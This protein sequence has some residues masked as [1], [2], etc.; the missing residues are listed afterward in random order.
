MFWASF[1]VVLVTGGLVPSQAGIFSVESISRDFERPFLLSTSFISAENQATKLTLRYAQSTYGIVSLNET[2][3]PYMARNY[4]L[5]P[6][7]PIDTS[8][9]D[10]SQGT[11]A[12]PTTMY[13]VDL[14]C[15]AT[16]ALRDPRPKVK[17]V[18]YKSNGGC[19]VTLGLTGNVTKGFNSNKLYSPLLVAK[20]Y[21]AMYI[22]YYNEGNADFSLKGNCPTEQNHTFYAAFSAN[23]LSDESPPNNVTAIFCEPT[24]Y[25]QRVN[26]TVDMITK[27]PLTVI[28]LGDK[29][30]IAIGMFNSTYLESQ[31]NGGSGY[32]VRGDTLPLKSLPDYLERIAETNVSLTT[33]PTGSGTVQPMVGLALEVSKQPLEKYLDWKVLSKSY[34]DAYRVLFARAMV[35]ILDTDFQSSENITGLQQITTEAVVLE[36]VF[37]YIVEGLLGV[38]SAATIVLLYL[39]ITRQRNLRWDPNTIAGIMS[40]VADDEALLASFEDLD[41]CTMAE[42]QER[43]S[44]RRYQ[45]VCDDNRTG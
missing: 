17:T 20:D 43:I 14:Y 30:P 40:L 12:A 42:V 9:L 1:A 39:S 26:A 29:Q 28:P 7:K 2:L 34:A 44:H 5:T 37:T 11:W 10:G 45:L 3:P 31:M 22:G 8:H 15:E 35:D 25:Q 36:P 6:F 32:E 19:N 27:R 38:I 24:Y 33:G 4:T 16:P 21:M 41:C 23:K 13:S 18:L